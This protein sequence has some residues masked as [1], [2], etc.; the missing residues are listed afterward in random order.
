VPLW[1]KNRD[2]EVI[3]PDSTAVLARGRLGIVP[4]D[5]P[6]GPDFGLY[7]D[8]R[9]RD[10]PEVT[11]PSRMIDWPDFGLPADE[12]DVFDAVVN[13][14]RRA[15][16]GEVVEIACYGGVGRTGTV[17]GCLTVLSGIPAPEA[18]A[19]VR[20]HYHPSAVETVAQEQLIGRFARAVEGGAR[21][22]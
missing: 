20:L 22:T 9:W 8:E 15:L 2:M 3:F 14:H 19:W 4:P 11:W 17:L 5:R 12:A 13:V 1:G 18:V 6:R 21:P 16:D 10:D 7:L